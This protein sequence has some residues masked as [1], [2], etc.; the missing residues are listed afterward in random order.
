MLFDWPHHTLIH[1]SRKFSLLGPCLKVSP[2]FE[3]AVNVAGFESASVDKCAGPNVS[4]F[5]RSEQAFDLEE[6]SLSQ[7]TLSR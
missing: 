7:A 1:P 4:P 3:A 2:G 6:Y 5:T